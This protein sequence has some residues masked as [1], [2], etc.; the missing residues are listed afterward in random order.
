MHAAFATLVRGARALGIRVIDRCNLTILRRKGMEHMADF[1]AE[2]EVDVIASLPCYSSA[3]VEKQRGSGVFLD[4]I[5]ALQE[6]NARGYGAAE[7]GAGAGSGSAAG[8]GS[9]RRLDLVYNPGG[10][11][12][13]PDQRTLELAYREKLRADFGIVFDSLFCITNMPIKRFADELAEEG[14]LAQ[15]MELLVTNF[16]VENVA[17]IMCRSMVHVAYDGSIHDCDF[18]YALELA[19][20]DPRKNS[21]HAL[22][23][24]F[25]ELAHEPIQ[26]ASHCWGCVAGAGSS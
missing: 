18:H 1:L 24:S 10:A 5:A 7:N 21:V 25:A 26:L 9:A 15:Y 16:R 14:A 22:R 13:P 2:N 17:G 3:N 6:L 23:T 11:F 4:S 20:P 8:V 12:L 19:Q